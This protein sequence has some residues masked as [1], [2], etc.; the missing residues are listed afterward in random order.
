MTVGWW[1]SLATGVAAGTHT[2]TWGMFGDAHHE[3]FTWA[4]YSRSI[5]LSAVI[6]LV[7]F[8]VSGLDATT[9]AG[10]VLLF[11]TTYT[12]ERAA[13]EF[14]KTFLRDQDQ[15]KF[16]IPMQ[17]AIKGEV[18]EDRRKRVLIGLAIASVV[19]GLFAGVVWLDRHRPDWPPL[20]QV[21]VVGTATGW[22]S[23]VGGA[24]KDAPHEGFELL[25]FF[26]SP[27]VAFAWALMVASLTT[28]W[29][30]LFV[31]PLG[32]TVATTETW[33]TFFHP[34]D[35]RGKFAGMPV[36]HPEMERRRW[37][38]VPVYAAI[39]LGL[40]VTIALALAGPSEGL[41]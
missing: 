14:W 20:V 25:K 18:V 39:W 33:K 23:A 7:V 41:I 19:L 26:R 3:G 21:L 8:A 37:N 34:H 9:P 17:F 2:A 13:N 40:I 28:S 6:A 36:R 29:I 5:V 27:A 35:T 32:Y 12:I 16:F 1:I 15:S 38:F 4:R 11:G 31:V 22:I 30:Y 24:W 10:I